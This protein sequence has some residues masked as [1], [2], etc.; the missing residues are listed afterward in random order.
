[1]P[2]VDVVGK[3]AGT[4]PPAQTVK[5]LPKLKAGVIFASTVTINV[6]DVAHTTASGMNVYVAEF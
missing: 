6:I 3:R 4:L 1:M 2:L 5:L